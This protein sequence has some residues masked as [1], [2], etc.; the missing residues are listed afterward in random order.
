MVPEKYADL[1]FEIT[2]FG[3]NSRV[4]RFDRRPIFV[5]NANNGIDLKL[6]THI[7]DT[8]LKI[9]ERRKNPSAS[10]SIDDYAYRDRK[11]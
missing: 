8:Y 9:T 1:G 10:S 4:L 6:L 11:Y 7:C 5:F 2:D 3:A